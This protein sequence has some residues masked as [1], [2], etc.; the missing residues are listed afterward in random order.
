MSQSLL[1]QEE[2][3]QQVNRVHRVP[4]QT[5]AYISRLEHVQEL[6][7][8]RKNKNTEGMGYQV[9]SLASIVSFIQKVLITRQ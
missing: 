1:L 8:M 5:M 3:N 2:M 6:L 7:D 4:M 9:L